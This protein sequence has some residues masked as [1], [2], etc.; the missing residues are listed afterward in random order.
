MPSQV[1]SSIPNHQGFFYKPGIITIDDDNEPVP[2]N[3]PTPNEDNVS[4][5][6]TNWAD[7]GVCGRQSKG[8]VDVKTQLQI[9]FA[10]LCL[11]SLMSGSIYSPN[12]LL[13]MLSYLLQINILMFLYSMR[14]IGLNL[15]MATPYCGYQNLFWSMLETTLFYS[16]PFR[17]NE[18]MS[19]YRYDSVVTA[20]QFTNKAPQ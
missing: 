17:V 14:F 12:H 4:I 13:S 19:R 2:E 15:L 3:T 11:I 7:P 9:W 8:G 6:F 18:I 20:L 10:M 1:Y 5:V 16:A